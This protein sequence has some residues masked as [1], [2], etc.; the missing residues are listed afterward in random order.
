MTNKICVYDQY[1]RGLFNDHFLFRIYTRTIATTHSGM[2][3]TVF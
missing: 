1:F 2:K 3:A